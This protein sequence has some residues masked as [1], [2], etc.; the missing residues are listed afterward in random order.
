[1]SRSGLVYEAVRAAILAGE[2]APMQALSPQELAT[3][4]GVSLAVAR[5]SLLRLVGEGL[6]ERITNRGFIVPAADSDRWQQIAEARAIVEPQAIR[7]AIERGDVAWEATVRATHHTLSRAP[8]GSEEW[9]AAHHAFHR[10]LLAGC[11]NPVL[12]DTFERMWDASQLTRIWS[13]GTGP[14]RDHVA[15]HAAL[16]RACLDRDA[17]QAAALLTAHLG[18]TA[19]GLRAQ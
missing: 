18:A 8:A 15:E 7:L 13:V 14:V 19:A 11:A 17:S 3:R 1:M 6:A 4:F 12:L 16:E 10:A 9:A 2:F 5:E